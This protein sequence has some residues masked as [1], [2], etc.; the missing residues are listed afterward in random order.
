MCI[1]YFRRHTSFQKVEEVKVEQEE[2][3]RV[4]QPQVVSKKPRERE[5][6]DSVQHRRKE[7]HDSGKRKE[8]HDVL[9]IFSVDQQVRED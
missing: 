4:G 6:T 7:R 8:K 5:S 9:G 2:A 3:P 1:C